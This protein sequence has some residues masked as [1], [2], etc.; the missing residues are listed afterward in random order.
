MQLEELRKTLAKNKTQRLTPDACCWPSYFAAIYF[1]CFSVI[2][3][4]VQVELGK[5]SPQTIYA[6]EVTDYYD[7]PAQE[8]A[9]Q[10]VPD[11][12]DFDP[13]LQMK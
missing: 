9:A 5:P 12:Y 2:S 7:Q 11:V 10:A 1:C 6:P 4:Q 3:R 8:E 13:L